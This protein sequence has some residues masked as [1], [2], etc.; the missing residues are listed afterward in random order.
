VISPL[1]ITRRSNLTTKF[2]PCI[3]ETPYAGDVNA[4]VHF[5]QCCMNDMLLRDE[6]PYASHLLYT[7]EN[8]LDDTKPD[9]R[10]RGIYAGFAWKHMEGVVTV[11]YDNYG[12]SRG[13]TLALDYCKE[14]EL[15]YEI[16]TLKG[17]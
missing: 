16:R 15:P 17:E 10:E 13:M 6:A 1:H 9:E 7:Q 2:K 8:V 11:F 4:N 3:L 12:M 14:N 5:A